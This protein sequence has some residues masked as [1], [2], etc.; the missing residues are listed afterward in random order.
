MHV[1]A[2]VRLCVRVFVPVCVCASVRHA[3]VCTAYVCE[4]ALAV[5]A[6]RSRS[7]RPA[8]APP[9]FLSINRYERKK[10]IGLAVRAFAALRGSLPPALFASARLTIAGGY[11]ERVAE[12]AAVYKELE[13]LVKVCGA[14]CV[15][16]CGC[17]CV[18]CVCVFVCSCVCVCVCVCACVCVFSCVCVCVRAWLCGRVCACLCVSVCGR[19]S[20]RLPRAQCDFLSVLTRRSRVAVAWHRGTDD[21]PAVVL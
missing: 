18:V 20:E 7:S 17:L 11:D 5:C 12:N 19:N 15:C 3:G 14:M 16:V 1:R 13:A 21:V 4:R 8:R 6:F 9:A 10:D 2:C